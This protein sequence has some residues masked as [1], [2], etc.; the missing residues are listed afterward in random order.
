MSDDKAYSSTS[1]QLNFICLI[2]HYH[3]NELF[4]LGQVLLANFYEIKVVI[5]C[6]LKQSLTHVIMLENYT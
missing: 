2:F 5:F 6:F 4:E 1:D 3:Y